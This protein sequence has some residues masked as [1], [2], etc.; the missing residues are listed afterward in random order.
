[1]SSRY[2][3]EQIL[4]EER[5]LVLPSFNENDAIALGLAILDRA[6]REKLIV[7]IEVHR[8]GR[9]IFKA[10]LPGTRKHN[11][12]MLAGKRRV[13]E[14]YGHSSLHE[15]LRHEAV[16]TSFEEVMGLGL[17]RFVAQGGGFPLFVSGADPVGGPVGIAIVSGLPHEDDHA[18]VVASARDYL[19]ARR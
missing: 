6:R 5:E 2:T 1:M 7:A 17:P 19:A 10:A 14:R 16:G 4:A 15:K 11:D 12:K 9:L 3:P 8:A 13:V 18:L